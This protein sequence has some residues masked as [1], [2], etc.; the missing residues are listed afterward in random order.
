MKVKNMHLLI[1]AFLG[2]VI[3]GCN[4][5]PQ[6]VKS[7]SELQQYKPRFIITEISGLKLKHP[8]FLYVDKEVWKLDNNGIVSSYKILSGNQNNPMFGLKALD[9]HGKKCSIFVVNNSGVA[10]ISFKYP[11]KIIFCKAS[12]DM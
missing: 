4:E 6:P 10:E 12:Y 2:L 8:A 7:K 11:D 1:L 5:N 3:A 9:N